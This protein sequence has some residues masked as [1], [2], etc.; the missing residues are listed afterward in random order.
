VGSATATKPYD[1]LRI[2]RTGDTD[3]KNTRK[4]FSCSSKYSAPVFNIY[5]SLGPQSDYSECHLTKMLKLFYQNFKRR[6]H[7]QS[8]KDMTNN[9]ISTR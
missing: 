2:L 5:A 6:R 1:A 3:A 8:D 7:L 9:F 4:T